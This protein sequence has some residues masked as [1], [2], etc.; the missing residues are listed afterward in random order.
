MVLSRTG[1]SA[2]PENGLGGQKDSPSD[3]F[4]AS[5]QF[6]ESLGKSAVF[7]LLS[8]YPAVSS[9]K[10][11]LIEAESFIKEYWR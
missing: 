9:R 4:P 3:Q 8:I 5:P 6:R 10:R 2:A 11:P 7:S 1:S